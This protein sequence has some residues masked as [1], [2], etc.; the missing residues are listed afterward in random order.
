MSTP[1]LVSKTTRP[2]SVSPKISRAITKVIMN[3]QRSASGPD[4]VVLVAP[5][6]GGEGWRAV[7]IGL[8]VAISRSLAHVFRRMISSRFQV[9]SSRSNGIHNTTLHHLG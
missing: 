5:R 8:V 6:D 9:A 7:T 1:S 3:N 4:L 2:V